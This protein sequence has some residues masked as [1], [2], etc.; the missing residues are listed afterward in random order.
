LTDKVKQPEALSYNETVALP[1][2]KR[3]LLATTLAHLKASQ[4]SRSVYHLQQR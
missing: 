2:N 4:E 1:L 3:L